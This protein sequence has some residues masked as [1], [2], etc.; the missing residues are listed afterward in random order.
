[1][2]VGLLHWHLRDIAKLQEESLNGVK[3]HEDAESG[4]LVEAANS[5]L[6]SL[7]APVVLTDSQLSTTGN[8]C[9]STYAAL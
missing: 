8:G 2:S 5:S 3:R 9:N 6:L 4:D 7:P 1:M